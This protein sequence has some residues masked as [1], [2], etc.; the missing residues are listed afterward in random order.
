MKDVNSQERLLIIVEL[1]AKTGLGGMSNKDLVVELKASAPQVCRDLAI[2]KKRGWVQQLPTGACRL[3]PFFGN[4]AN[5]LAQHF[6]Q[7]K[8]D[9]AAE[10]DSYFSNRK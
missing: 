10:E 4:F 6:R 1:L 9:L 7:A 5:Q 8:L 2:L 3:A